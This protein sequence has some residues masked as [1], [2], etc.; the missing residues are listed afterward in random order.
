MTVTTPLVDIDGLTRFLNDRRLGHGAVT[1]AA[2]GEGHSNPTFVVERGE[3]RWVLR[4][5]PRPPL[6]PSA[7]DVLRE[8]RI[9]QALSGRGPR[10][11]VPVASCADDTVIGAP[12]YLMDFLD[13]HV[14]TTAVPEE[15]NNAADRHHIGEQLVDTLTEIHAL[16]WRA[17]GLGDFGRPDGYLD[18][19]VARFRRAWETNQTRELPL[20]DA[21]GAQLNAAIPDSHRATIVHGDYRLGN[22][23][24]APASPA[25]VI[26]VFDWELATIG[27]PLADLGYLLASWIEPGD[28]TGFFA[29]S[30]IVLADAPD[31]AALLA[32][33]Q[34]RT[35]ANVER[36]AWYQALAHWKLAVILEGSYK[37]LL[38]GATDDTWLKGMADAIPQL[39][40]RAHDVLARDPG[41]N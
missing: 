21:V 2:I 17:S 34:Q 37:R 41:T 18:R 19:Q 4:R 29:A 12:F 10:V 20:I 6:P 25:R 23:M 31:R 5:P 8:Y 33:Y 35:G 16:D 22:V 11:P 32:R 1:V 39:A 40:E 15:L 24:I 9:L 14:I 3:Q 30:T 7:H 26:A 27:D 38:A 13:G 36:I 28:E